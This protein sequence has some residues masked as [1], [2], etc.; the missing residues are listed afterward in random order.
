M[1]RC[2]LPQPCLH[3]GYGLL[4]LS[5][6]QKKLAAEQIARKQKYF[7]RQELVF[8]QHQVP[9]F[10]AGLTGNNIQTPGFH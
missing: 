10:S 9:F 4:P 5:L 1:H 3:G 8:P 2:L 7:E 6:E